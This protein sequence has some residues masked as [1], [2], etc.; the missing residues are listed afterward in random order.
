MSARDPVALVIGEFG[1]GALAG[2]YGR[3]LQMLGWRV[4]SYDMQRGYTRGHTSRKSHIAPRAL[5]P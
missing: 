2:Y 3:A 4:V 5:G 1:P